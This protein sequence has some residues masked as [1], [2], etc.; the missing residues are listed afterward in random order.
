MK[1]TVETGTEV[2]EMTI[3]QVKGKHQGNPLRRDPNWMNSGST[4]MASTARC[5]KVQYADFWDLKP[6][7]GPLISM[8]VDIIFCR[9][10]LETYDL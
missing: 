5:Y 1:W 10:G 4:E 6:H 9:I 2:T 7:L 3:L 8:F